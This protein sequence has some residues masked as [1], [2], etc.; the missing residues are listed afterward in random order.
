LNN[1]QRTTGRAQIEWQEVI[2]SRID[3]KKDISILSRNDKFRQRLV[4]TLAGHRSLRRGVDL[5]AGQ[6]GGG[7]GQG[8]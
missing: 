5:E 4:D 2:E 1:S 7:V 3:W 6:N 8:G